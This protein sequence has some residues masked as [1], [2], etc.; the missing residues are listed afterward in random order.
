[1]VRVTRKDK[2]DVEAYVQGSDGVEHRVMLSE[3]DGR[4]TCPWYSKHPGER[5]PCSHL[6]A[7]EIAAGRAGAE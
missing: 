2:E 7:V 1:M 5:G 4:C 3:N 6:L